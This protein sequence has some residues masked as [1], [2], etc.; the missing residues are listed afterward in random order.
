MKNSDSLKPYFYHKN[1]HEMDAIELFH[2]IE[3][4]T[5]LDLKMREEKIIQL[6]EELAQF[7]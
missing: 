3:L 2:N 1:D 6:L 5:H 7:Y 4:K